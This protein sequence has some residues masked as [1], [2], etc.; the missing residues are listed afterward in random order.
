MK[1]LPLL[2]EEE[3]EKRMEG[4]NGGEITE[5]RKER[6]DSKKKGRTKRRKYKKKGQKKSRKKNMISDLKI[7]VNI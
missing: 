2:V 1:C 7:T 6:Q 3:K 4:H 5:V